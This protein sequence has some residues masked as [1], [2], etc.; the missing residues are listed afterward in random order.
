MPPD[1]NRALFTG[2]VSNWGILSVAPK[3]MSGSFLMS[4]TADTMN[5]AVACPAARRMVVRDMTVLR[6]RFATLKRTSWTR[7]VVRERFW[8][9]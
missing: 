9:R 7:A 2:L 3:K 8:R 5:D 4:M 1:Q 6:C